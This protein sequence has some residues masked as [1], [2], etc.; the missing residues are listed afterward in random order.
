MRRIAPCNGSTEPAY[1][2]DVY[3]AP[4]AIPETFITV[5]MV[6]D[7]GAD[8]MCGRGTRVWIVVK[9]NDPSGPE[10]V[11]KDCWIDSD[12][13]HEG[14]VL[15]EISNISLMPAALESKADFDQ[16]RRHFLEVMIHGG[17]VTRC[18]FDGAAGLL[19][20]PETVLDTTLSVHRGNL[21]LHYGRRVD[22]SKPIRCRKT[23]SQNWEGRKIPSTQTA[24]RGNVP[25]SFDHTAVPEGGES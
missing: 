24:G 9:K 12:R 20:D 25:L 16:Y 21:S 6:A 4:D 22:T 2:I 8:A 7:F 18:S 13:A 19:D 5:R 3:S 23:S 15:Q 14:S 11:L 1:E 17:V 10:H